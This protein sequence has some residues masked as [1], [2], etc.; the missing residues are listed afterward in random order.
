MNTSYKYI[1]TIVVAFITINASAQRDSTELKRQVS[2]DRNLDP[3]VKSANKL[4]TLPTIYTPPVGSSNFSYITSAPQISLDHNYLGRSTPSEVGTTIDFSKKRGYITLGA[5]TH[6]NLD[7]AV[8][9]RVVDARNDRLD[10]FATHSSTKADIDYLNGSKYIFD[11]VK[12]KYANTV[13]NL[14]YQH[15]FDMSL[16]TVDGSYQNMSYNYYGNSFYPKDETFFPFDVSSR[17]RVQIINVGASARSFIETEEGLKYR[18]GIRYRN[19]KSKYGFAT[20]E[21]G[22]KG[23]LFNFDIDLHSEFGADKELGITGNVT[24]QSF[25]GVNKDIYGADAFHGFTNITASPYF[26]LTGLNWKISLGLNINSIFDVKTKF[27]FTPNVIAETKIYEVNTIYAKVTGG[28]NENTYIDILQENRYATPLSRIEYSKTKY[29]LT[30]GFKSGVI[31]GLEF[32]VFAGYKKTDKDHL[33]IAQSTYVPDPAG[34]PN[35]RLY[36]ANVGTPAYA[37]IATGS[38]GG[39]IKTLLI[40]YTDLSAKAT[41]YFYNVKYTD[42]YVNFIEKEV[43]AEQK[44][45]G[46]PSFTFDLSADV[47]PIDNLILSLGYM[48]GL[49]R[50][51]YLQDRASAKYQSVKMKDINELNFRAEYQIT[52]WVSANFR[53]NNLLFQKY[54]LQHGYPMQGFNFLGGLSFKF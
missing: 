29:D 50:K 6:N 38:V 19:F 37:N 21:K 52:D 10:I 42:G 41:A 39:V 15:L 46:R 27:L 43:F 2:I 7:G 1:L 4:N 16:I 9:Y 22:P 30:I 44:A 17:Q 35:E 8:G 11:D 49:G 20:D 54:E 18:G 31:S 28:V 45:W 34:E 36:L 23:G 14:K 12:A 51:A 47:K 5:G 13:A 48:L 3:S 26:N 40:P 32:D 24:N 33:Y 53:L 25:S